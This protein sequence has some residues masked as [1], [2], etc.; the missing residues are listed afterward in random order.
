MYSIHLFMYSNIIL[1]QTGQC[2]KVFQ[3]NIHKFKCGKFVISQDFVHCF[4]LGLKKKKI[5]L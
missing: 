4:H 2:Q 1:A 3:L 5:F